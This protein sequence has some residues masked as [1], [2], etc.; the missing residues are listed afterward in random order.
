MTTRTLF[1]KCRKMQKDGLTYDQIAVNLTTDGDTTIKGKKP[2]GPWVSW[3]L[4]RS[5][6]ATKKPTIKARRVPVKNTKTGK[7]LTAIRSLIKLQGVTSDDKLAMI[8]LVLD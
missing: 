7:Q 2:N 3:L 8:E 6:Y 5:Q 4:N 1:N